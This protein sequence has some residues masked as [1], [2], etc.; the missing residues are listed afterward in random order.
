MAERTVEP[1]GPRRDERVGPRNVL[2]QLLG[3]PELGAV[4]GAII[5]WVFFASVA[6]DNG[7]PLPGIG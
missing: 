7:F 2:R 4:G 6:G 1:A 5:V 3:R